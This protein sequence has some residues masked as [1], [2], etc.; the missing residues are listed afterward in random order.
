[1]ASVGI[2]LALTGSTPCRR[3]NPNRPPGLLWCVLMQYGRHLEES[4][5]GRV[6]QSD[7]RSSQQL[8]VDHKLQTKSVARTRIFLDGQTIGVTTGAE[9]GLTNIVNGLKHGRFVTK[10][11]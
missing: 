7:C 2:L 4:Y 3:G 11:D 6:S 1:M 5:Q 8:P 9:R 10:L